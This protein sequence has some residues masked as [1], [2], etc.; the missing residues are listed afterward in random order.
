MPTSCGNRWFWHD[1]VL[2]ARR[3]KKHHASG[4]DDVLIH[5]RVDAQAPAGGGV[6]DKVERSHQRLDGGLLRVTDRTRHNSWATPLS[7]RTPPLLSSPPTC[8]ALGMQK[9]TKP[10]GMFEIMAAASPQPAGKHPRRTPAKPAKPGQRKPNFI[11]PLER[12]TIL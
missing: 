9:P 8:Y 6:A 2:T 4:P 10:R 5:H 12:R 11:E 1:T 3:A 7:L